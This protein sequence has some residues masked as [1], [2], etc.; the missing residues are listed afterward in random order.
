MD[1]YK[2]KDGFFRGKAH[3]KI[4]KLNGWVELVESEDVYVTADNEVIASDVEIKGGLLLSERPSN[5]HQNIK[6]EWVEL[7]DKPVPNTLEALTLRVE[8]IEKS[9]KRS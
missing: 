9:L 3:H 7:E 6:G 4:A 1:K 8:A 5:A 2:D